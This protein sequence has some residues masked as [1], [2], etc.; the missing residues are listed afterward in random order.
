MFKACGIETNCK[1]DGRSKMAV[2]VGFHS[3][4]HSFVTVAAL[5]GL[6]SDQLKKLIEKAVA[7]LK[8]LAEKAKS[9]Q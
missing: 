3:L 8:K 4:R 2:E 5:E 9:V 6:T 1:V 7:E